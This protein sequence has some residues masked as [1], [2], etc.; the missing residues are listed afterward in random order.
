M[1][2][3]FWLIVASGYLNKNCC[4]DGHSPAKVIF[5]SVLTM[6]MAITSLCFSTTLPKKLIK[7]IEVLVTAKHNRLIK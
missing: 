2:I 5:H 4:R 7:F 6:V 1:K 3:Q